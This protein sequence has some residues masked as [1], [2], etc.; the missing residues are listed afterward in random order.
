MDKTPGRFRNR[1]LVVFVMIV[2]VMAA[3]AALLVSVGL[4]GAPPHAVAAKE[5]EIAETVYVTRSGKKY[6]R[7]GCRYLR[8]EVRAISLDR[9]RRFYEPCKVCDPP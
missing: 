6:H 5:E 9:A 1:Q 3:G 8:S 4:R 2:A 7:E